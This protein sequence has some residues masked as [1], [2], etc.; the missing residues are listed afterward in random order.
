MAEWTIDDIKTAFFRVHDVAAGKTSQP[1]MSIPADKERD[2]DCI[3]LDGLNQLQARYDALLEE[4][5]GLVRVVFN[6]QS[7]LEAEGLGIGPYMALA[8]LSPALKAKVGS[9]DKAK[10]DS[11]IL[12]VER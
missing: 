11:M 9:G 5:T 3:V 2:A 12:G 1:Y 10:E 6:V 8:N 7:F 4:A